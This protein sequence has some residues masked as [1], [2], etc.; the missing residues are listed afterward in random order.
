[1]SYNGQSSII[2]VIPSRK[3]VAHSTVL[4]VQ[5]ND[6][7]ISYN[8]HFYLH[9]YCGFSLESSSCINGYNNSDL[10]SDLDKSAGYSSF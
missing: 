5:L 7:I 9:I 1:M 3:L 6:R 8:F 4:N 2:H 10:E